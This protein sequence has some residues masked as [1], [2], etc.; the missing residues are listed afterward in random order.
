MFST[1]K[2]QP[3][4]SKCPSILGRGKLVVMSLDC[5]RG[6]VATGV[7]LIGKG[8]LG[9]RIVSAV[10]HMTVRIHGFKAECCTV[11]IQSISQLFLMLWQIGVFFFLFP[12]AF[13]LIITD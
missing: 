10:I 8:C 12:L 3:L 5:S 2:S 7:H 9:G 13:M 11:V 6:A 4:F 1:H